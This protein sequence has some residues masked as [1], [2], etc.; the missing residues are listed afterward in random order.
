VA[1]D[2]RTIRLQDL[3]GAGTS[4]RVVE[5]T[6]RSSRGTSVIRRLRSNEA[7]Q[8]PQ[9]TVAVLTLNRELGVTYDDAR[10]RDCWRQVEPDDQIGDVEQAL[11]LRKC[12]SFD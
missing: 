12:R 8:Q 1:S 11:D 2:A 5:R 3:F 10:D 9:S 7:H 6:G 4:L